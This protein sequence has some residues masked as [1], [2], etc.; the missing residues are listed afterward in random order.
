MKIIGIYD[1]HNASVSLIENNKLICSVEEEKFSKLKNHDTRN[2][3]IGAPINALNFCLSKTKYNCKYFVLALCDPSILVKKSINFFFESLKKKN[4]K[5]RNNFFIQSNIDIKNYEQYIYK[6]QLNRIN[7]IKN[8][9]KKYVKNP[10]IKLIPHH[11]AHAASSYYSSGLNKSIVFSFDGRGDALSGS[12]YLANKGKLNL[13]KEYDFINSIGHFYSAITVSCGFKAIR[14]E[15]K[16]TGLSASGIVRKELL[17]NFKSLIFVKNGN[18]ISNL[19]SNVALG[20]YPHSL[21]GEAIKKIKKITKNYNIRDISATAQCYTETLVLKLINH[22]CRKYKYANLCLA[23]GLFANVLINKKILEQKYCKSI[24]IHPAMSDGGISYGAAI[25]YYNKFKTKKKYI[26]LKK[27]NV[28][29]GP[30]ISTDNI[31][32]FLKKKK[33]NFRIYKNAENKVAQLLYKKKIISRCVG[34]LEYGPR[35]L[36]NRSILFHAGDEK[37]NIWLNKQLN[38]SEFMPFAPI[39][40]EENYNKFLKIKKTLNKTYKFMTIAA[41]TTQEMKD[42][43]PSVVHIDGT[44]RPQILSKVDNPKLYNLLKK[45]YELSSIPCLI[46]TSFNLHDAPMVCNSKDAIES[47]IESKL[48]YLQLNNYIISRFKNFE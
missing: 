40:L 34:S 4:F 46:N 3:S 10:I 43:S 36:G 27:F 35:A 39:L 2:T 38:R 19:Y 45:Y 26:P 13:I 9:I 47:F 14:H 42:K 41:Q 17:G 12:I 30:K 29:I 20:P 5:K 25:S 18:I 32:N 31:E 8:I 23:G 16:I 7:N 44:V 1:G 37:V 22:F 6:Y 48:D 15:G 28:Y 24:F 33:L 21:F 11:E